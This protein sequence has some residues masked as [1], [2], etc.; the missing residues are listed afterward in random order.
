MSL[1]ASST[2]ASSILHAKSAFES[3]L[4]SGVGLEEGLRV[5]GGVGAAVAGEVLGFVVAGAGAGAADFDPPAPPDVR[6]SHDRS[7]SSAAVGEPSKPSA[8]TDASASSHARRR[9]RRSRILMGGLSH[10]TSPWRNR[11][12]LRHLPRLSRDC[13]TLGGRIRATHAR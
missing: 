8:K 3:F 6:S 2:V 11:N 13:D 1:I 9:G 12:G 5:G 7:K 10:T 4:G